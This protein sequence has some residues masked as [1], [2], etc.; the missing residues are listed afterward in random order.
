MDIRNMQ[1]IPGGAVAMIMHSMEFANG[2]E[3]AKSI[4][5]QVT[6]QLG[7]EDYAGLSSTEC[8]RTGCTTC[9]KWARIATRC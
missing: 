5:T 7:D 6:R 8:R 4:C 9:R 3:W 1:Y 2:N